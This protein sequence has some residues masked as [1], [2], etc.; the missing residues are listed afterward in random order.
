MRAFS[1]K[2]EIRLPEGAPTRRNRCCGLGRGAED[3]GETSLWRP[4]WM[5]K[6]GTKAPLPALGISRSARQA[7]ISRASCDALRAAAR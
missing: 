3:G 4:S 2:M 1:V 7:L 6:L 5:F